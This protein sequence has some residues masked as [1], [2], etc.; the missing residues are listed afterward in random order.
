MFNTDAGVQAPLGFKLY[1][2]ADL[3]VSTR[4][5]LSPLAPL[6]ADRVFTDADFDSDEESFMSG[7]GA[8]VLARR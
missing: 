3:E 1:G 6:G 5:L 2:R 4:K 8:C 7:Q